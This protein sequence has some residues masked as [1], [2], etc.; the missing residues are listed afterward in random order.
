MLIVRGV[1]LVRYVWLVCFNCI[2]LL[3]GL[4][5]MCVSNMGPQRPIEKRVDFVHMISSF[6]P[7][8]SLTHTSTSYLISPHPRAIPVDH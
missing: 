3:W 2:L 6:F 8:Y 5:W 7:L 1:M 4:D